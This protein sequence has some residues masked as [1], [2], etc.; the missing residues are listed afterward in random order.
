MHHAERG[1]QVVVAEEECRRGRAN[2][3]S[4]RRGSGCTEAGGEG[5]GEVGRADDYCSLGMLEPPL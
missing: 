2:Q 3:G 5:P 4:G 1:A